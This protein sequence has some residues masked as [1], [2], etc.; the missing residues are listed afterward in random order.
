MACFQGFFMEPG[1]IEPPPSCLQS[2]SAE[3]ADAVETPE[4]SGDLGG[5]GAVPD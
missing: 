3:R 1:G 2:S 4:I 5:S